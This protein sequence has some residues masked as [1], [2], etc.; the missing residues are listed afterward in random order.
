MRFQCLGFFISL[1]CQP[2]NKFGIF[3]VH[4]LTFPRSYVMQ[5]AHHK[6]E[7]LYL[8]RDRL[9]IPISV[10]MHYLEEGCCS[11]SGR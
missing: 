2:K 4:F 8:F 9:F 3:S 11:T 1:I 10:H 5:H 6:L 7:N